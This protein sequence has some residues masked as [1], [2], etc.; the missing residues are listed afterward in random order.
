V[1]AMFTDLSIN[2]TQVV[3]SSEVWVDPL[4]GARGQ[5]RFG[6]DN[7]WSFISRVDFGGFG[8]GSDFTWNFIGMFGYDFNLIRLPST[9]TFGVR[10]FGQDYDNGIG[11][12]RFAWD[13]AQWG[14]MFGLAMHF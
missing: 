11:K 13:V 1:T 2:F 8:A 14:P 6:N 7:R 10:G 3:D 4:L 9:V 12:A 5:L